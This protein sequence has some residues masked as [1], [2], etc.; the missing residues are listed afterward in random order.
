MELSLA[1]EIDR[2]AEQFAALS[3]PPRIQI[4]RLLLAAHKLGGMAAGQIQ[5]ELH[6]P[7]STLTHHLGKLVSAG[8]LRSRRDRQWIW[9]AVNVDG[10]R[11]LLSF[12]FQECCTRTTV[13]A[14]E[15]LTMGRKS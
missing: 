8:L 14:P 5:A 6:I 3:S 11:D 9:Y 1:S 12:L 10:L 2:K 4:V 15:E 7:G 13:I